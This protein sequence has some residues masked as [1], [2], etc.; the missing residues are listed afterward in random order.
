MP[1]AVSP[2]PITAATVCNA[3]GNDWE[4]VRA[5]LHAGRSGLGPNRGIPV[6][7]ETAVG[8]VELDLPELEGELAGWQTRSAQIAAHML[9]HLDAE[10]ERMRSRWKPDRVAVVLGT[11]TAGADATE[12][13]YRNFIETGHLPAEYD[14]WRHHTYGAILHVVR[15]LTGARGPSWMVST[16]CTS[17]AKVL[18]SAQRLIHSGVADAAI[19]GGI[20]TLC[21]MTL[22]G[23]YSL[24]ALSA[25]PCRPF[26]AERRGI[27]IG[28]GG[29]LLLM[30]RQGDAIALIEGVGES[31][32]AYHV[33]APHPRGE[34]AEAAMR[35]ALGQAALRPSDV[36]H[37][38][39]HGTGTR[40]NDSAEATAIERL[41]GTEV[42]VVSTKCYTGH[43]LGGA[44]GTEAAFAIM[45]LHGGWIPAA[46]GVDPLDEEVSIRIP[47]ERVDGELR[48]V[49]SNS[50][51]FGGNNISVLLRSP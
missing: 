32:D 23:F 43:T 40:L 48:R 31:S 24:G 41:F 7:F 34:G 12:A 42:P 36:D 8:A 46:L 11:S 20:D 28:E 1:E 6:P 26:S 30:E 13:A 50:F 47:T 15:Q 25:E 21:A 14:L 9:G 33:S 29:A 16:A 35:R 49:L 17:S 19:V 18:A 39:A 38:N 27:S 2:I 5:E 37:I 22:S 51:A 10:L 3:L 45:A 4:S 44:G